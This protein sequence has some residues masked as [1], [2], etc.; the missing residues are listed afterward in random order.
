MKNEESMNDIVAKKNRIRNLMLQD[1]MSKE[2]LDQ[3]SKGFKV[4]MSE[5]QC[6]FRAK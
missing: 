3:M 4:V 5:A 6:A 1:G 2:Q